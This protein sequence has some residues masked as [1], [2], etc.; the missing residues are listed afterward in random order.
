MSYT[1]TSY[2]FTLALLS[3]VSLHADNEVLFLEQDG[4]KYLTVFAHGLG[5]T[6]ESVHQ[7]IRAYPSS[8]DATSTTMTLNTRY[9][10]DGP[11]VSF[12]FPDTDSTKGFDQ[13]KSCIGQQEDM[14][15][16]GHIKNEM[17]GAGKNTPSKYDGLIYVGVSRGAAT[18]INYV[19]STPST[20][21]Q[22]K[23]LIL[24]S[25]F[26]SI[27]TVYKKIAHN[28]W[29]SWLPCKEDI[30]NAA[31]WRFFPK[32]NSA[33]ICPDKVVHMLPKDCVIIIIG[34][35]QD[36]LVPLNCQR[37]LYCKLKK[38]GH[39]K[40]Y[41]VELGCG[42]HADLIHG[43]DG[44]CYQ[45]CVHALLAKHKLPHNALF[46]RKGVSYAAHCQP[47]VEDVEKCMKQNGF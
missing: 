1:T 40:A 44:E 6:Y 31:L 4:G 12:N 41:L 36:R 5:A 34:S 13:K 17:L 8:K 42:E 26:D 43:A 47:D 37:N 7:Y 35:F 39:K 25:P 28:A 33:G 38:A 2:F 46:A 19:A 14:A 16:L 18:I 32:Y 21:K 11:V 30:G 24:E 20:H 27:N 22:V 3:M 23:A 10:V 29:L 45:N 15:R 9:L